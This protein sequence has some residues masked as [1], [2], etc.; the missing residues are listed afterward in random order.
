MYFFVFRTKKRKDVKTVFF[1]NYDFFLYAGVN[2]NF[3][4]R[5]SFYLNKILEKKN[6]KYPKVYFVFLET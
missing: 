6:L 4:G 5:K 3:H 2:Y 1:E